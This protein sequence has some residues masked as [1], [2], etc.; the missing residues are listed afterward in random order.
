MC[1][2][3][4]P[5]ADLTLPI[6]KDF[7]LYIQLWCCS[8]RLFIIA[9]VGSILFTW[10]L[11]S[12][13]MGVGLLLLMYIMIA[14]DTYISN[15]IIL[16]SLWPAGLNIKTNM[17]LFMEQCRMQSLNVCNFI[18]TF[19]YTVQVRYQSGWNWCH[20]IQIFLLL[21]PLIT[22]QWSD[23]RISCEIDNKLLIFLVGTCT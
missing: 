23:I 18:H 17:G 2:C 15:D 8:F 16:Y 3:L 12:L 10:W 7:W 5:Y 13:W 11:G 4:L 9:E 6:L 14:H 21:R 22:N 19:N 1:P 20:K